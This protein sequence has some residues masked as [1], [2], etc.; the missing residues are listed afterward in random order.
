MTP[1]A[2]AV[3]G[4][5]ASYGLVLTKNSIGLKKGQQA[6]RD[7]DPLLSAPENLRTLEIG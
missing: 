5:L 7:E 2:G 3:T 6:M 4:M 1:T